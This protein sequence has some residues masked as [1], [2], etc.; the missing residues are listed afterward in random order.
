M[1]YNFRKVKLNPDQTYNLEAKKA[2]WEGPFVKF[3]N[4]FVYAT[5]AQ[6]HL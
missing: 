4:V 6:R 3:I 2:T 1:Q 5:H